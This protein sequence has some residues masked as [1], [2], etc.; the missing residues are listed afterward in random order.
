MSLYRES[1]IVFDLQSP[2]FLVHIPLISLFFPSTTTVF[3]VSKKSY[4]VDI[5]WST[6]KSCES[7]KSQKCVMWINCVDGQIV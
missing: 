5:N 3:E 7:S 2:S 6:G 4:I 1:N